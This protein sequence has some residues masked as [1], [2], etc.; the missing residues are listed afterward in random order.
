MEVPR[1]G[2]KSELQLPTYATAT[3][4]GHLSHVHSLHHS[5]W[6]CQILNPLSKVRDWTHILM[7]TSWVCY[8]WGTTRTP[9][10]TVFKIFSVWPS[11]L[12]CA[13]NILLPCEFSIPASSSTPTFSWPLLS[14]VELTCLDLQTSPPAQRLIDHSPHP[15]DP[16]A[17]SMP[18]VSL[19][20]HC[21]P[22]T[23]ACVLWNPSSSHICV[24]ELA[25]FHLL[26]IAAT[27]QLPGPSAS[28][29]MSEAPHHTWLLLAIFSW[30]LC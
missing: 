15:T 14:S 17:G 30:F 8:C 24:I 5:S 11:S 29:L 23:F 7:D 20:P 28:L 12:S 26:F 2:V 13:V 25:H 16:M 19:V 1:L 22:Q 27:H 3:A 10:F 21:H 4:I 9:V 18:E 6:H